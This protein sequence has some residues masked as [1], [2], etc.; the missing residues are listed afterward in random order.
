MSEKLSCG[1]GG[2]IPVIDRRKALAGE[3][4]VRGRFEPADAADRELRLSFRIG[5]QL[6][7]RRTV[8]AGRIA[9]AGT[10]SSNDSTRSPSRNGSFQYLAS[11]Y[12]PASTNL[13]NSPFVTSSLSIQKSGSRTGCRDA[14]AVEVRPARAPSRASRRSAAVSV[15]RSARPNGCSRSRAAAYPGFGDAHAVIAERHLDVAERGLAERLPR[16]V[17]RPVVLDLDVAPVGRR[18]QISACTRLSHASDLRGR[19]RLCLP[20]EPHGIQRTIGRLQPLDLGDRLLL[21]PSRAPA[22]CTVCQMPN[23]GGGREQRSPTGTRTAGRRQVA[24]AGRVSFA[25]LASS[26]A[27]SAAASG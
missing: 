25:W 5:S 21:D 22:T 19:V 8:P 12:P 3:L 18:D 2:P 16:R 26:S 23:A 9:K 15:N 27:R 11:R 13:L 4:G 20:G 14:D 1:A 24:S 17:E 6:P 7:R 10:A